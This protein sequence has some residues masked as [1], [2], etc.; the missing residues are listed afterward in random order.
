MPALVGDLT[1]AQASYDSLYGTIRSRWEKKGDSFSLEVQ[2]P[3]NATATVYIPAAKIDAVKESGRPAA[4][5]EAIQLIR[6]DHDYAVYRVGSG[7]YR[8]EK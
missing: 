3:V 7:T 4:V 5:T 2:V 6:R 8:F 1:S